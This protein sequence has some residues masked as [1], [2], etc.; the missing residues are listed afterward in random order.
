MEK[1][2]IFFDEP[3]H[4]YKDQFENP[5]TSATT[6]V[7]KYYTKFDTK[8]RARQCALAGLR[9][10]PKYA[11]KTAA[12][13]EREWA[14]T[15]AEA[16][17]KGTKKHNILE[18]AIKNCNGYKTVS[19]T[20][21]SQGRLFTIDDIIINDSIG[22]VLLEDFDKED[23]I[24]KYP[25]IYNLITFFINKG[26]KLYAEVGVYNPEYLISGQIDLLLIN[27]ETGK[28]A[29]IDWKTNKA[30]IRFEA[31]YYKKDDNG[32]LT[33][34]FNFTNAKF[35]HPVSHLAD[36]VGNHYTLQL[37]IY[38]Y[39]VLG[40]GFEFEANILCHIRDVVDVDTVNEVVELYPIKFLKK[41]VYD[42]F[43]DNKKK[44]NINNQ[45][46]LSI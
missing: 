1:R 17:D 43:N 36:S 37:S 20:I 4:S 44:S 9:G 27:F 25:K 33:D 38:D 39:L 45:F 2:T 3:S 8:K 13:L 21:K 28:Y 10:N 23:I 42:L 5:Y 14:E 18:T 6:L 11:G 22:R 31:G 19:S 7:G 30:P 34:E 15:T 46:I 24:T 40:F 12:Q 35:L 26:Y 32:N 16:C 29:I 41:E